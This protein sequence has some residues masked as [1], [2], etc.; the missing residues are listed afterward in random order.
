M[1]EDRL[2][3]TSPGLANP[4]L[5]KRRTIN[6]SSYRTRKHPI[7]E[8]L[9]D[10]K[11]LLICSLPRFTNMPMVCHSRGWRGYRRQ[12]RARAGF[13][14]C[15]N[16]KLSPTPHGGKEIPKEGP[17]TNAAAI[18]Q[19][20]SMIKKQEA[21]QKSSSDPCNNNQSWARSNDYETERWGI[22]RDWD[23]KHRR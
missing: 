13:S 19:A 11:S 6:A 2:K 1:G 5:V 8:Q 17:L 15:Q 18:N 14:F 21:E 10:T 7:H 4:A 3:R 12:A 22:E 20:N 23:K 16:V 9:E